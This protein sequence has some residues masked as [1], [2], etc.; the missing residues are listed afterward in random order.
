ML[1][2]HELYQYKPFDGS[3]H[4][5]AQNIL[6]KIS[7]QAA[8]LD[9]GAGSG[10]MGNYLKSIDITDI[11]AVEIDPE[12]QEHLSTIYKEVKD[13]ISAFDGKK[14][15]VVLL[16]D[17]LEHL[18]NPRSFLQQLKSYLAK[19]ALIL[20]SIPNIAHWSIRFSLLFGS[21]NYTERGILDRSHLHFFTRKSFKRL[22]KESGFSTLELS[23]SVIPLELIL[24]KWLYSNIFFKFFTLIRK[25]GARLHPSFGAFQHLALLKAPSEEF[26]EDK[27]STLN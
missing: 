13:D 2:A 20:V 21:F 19:D 10:C 6:A 26:F 16:L 25:S 24:P 5:W 23:Q 22:V 7:P 14:F 12:A 18:P 1:P 27:I 8:V 3:S 17:I 11:Y 15:D 9:F 4:L